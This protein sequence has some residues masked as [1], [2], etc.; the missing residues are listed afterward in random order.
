MDNNGNSVRGGKTT[1]PFFAG[2][3]TGSLYLKEFFTPENT[4]CAGFFQHT[5]RIVK[6]DYSF[7]VATNARRTMP[8]APRMVAIPTG[9]FVWI[10]AGPDGQV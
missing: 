1:F 4:P 8:M 7:L 6:K 9:A 10:G 2:Q 3:C 5:S